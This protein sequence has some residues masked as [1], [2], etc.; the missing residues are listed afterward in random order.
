M[1]LILGAMLGPCMYLQAHIKL[2]CCLTKTDCTPA[3]AH[4]SWH[5]LD[6]MSTFV[7]RWSTSL[8]QQHAGTSDAERYTCKRLHEPAQPDLAAHSCGMLVHMTPRAVRMHMRTCISHA[9][10]R[11]H[12][13]AQPDPA[14]QVGGQG[15][16]AQVQLHAGVLCM[17]QPV[18]LSAQ[19]A[20]HVP[21]PQQ[22]VLG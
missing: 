4:M 1:H 15:R 2:R 5:S 13:A 19:Q 21:I 14:A 12:E 9:C 8:H 16:H 11:L 20:Q 18:A 3:S 7:A 22:P 17:L 10:K 6:Q